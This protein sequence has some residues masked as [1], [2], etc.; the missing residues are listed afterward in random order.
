MQDLEIGQVI[1]IVSD[2]SGNIVPAIVA[3]ESVVRTLEGNTTS[4][5]LYVGSESNRKI[6]DSKQVNGE[7]YS[8]I[9][10]VEQV[11]HDRLSDFLKT[12]IMETKERARKWYGKYYTNEPEEVSKTETDGAGRIDPDKLLESV[13]KEPAKPIKQRIGQATTIKKQKTQKDSLRD[14]IMPS[15][16]ELTNNIITDERG[17][18]HQTGPTMKKIKMPDGSYVDVAVEVTD[19]GVNIL[20]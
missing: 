18:Q 19:Q 12:T 16:E 4:W 5:K 1:Y 14:M 20:E 9:E 13:D 6:I 2:K 7:V 15:Q 3:E 10:E 8:T 11:L 17:T